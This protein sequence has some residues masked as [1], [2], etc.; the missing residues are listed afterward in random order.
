MFVILNIYVERKSMATGSDSSN[1]DIDDENNEVDY[2][3][4]NDIS[5]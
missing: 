2:D 5:S 1:S 3:I 4:S